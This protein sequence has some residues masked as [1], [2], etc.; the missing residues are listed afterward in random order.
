MHDART[1]AQRE[2]LDP[3]A[4]F[5]N[6]ERGMLLLSKREYARQARHGWVRGAEPVRYVDEIRKRYIAYIDH[7][8]QLDA[9]TAAHTRDDDVTSRA[10][11]E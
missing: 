9:R 1:V 11:P 10:A 2:G 8:D 5:G 7:F 6:V 3:N 4:W